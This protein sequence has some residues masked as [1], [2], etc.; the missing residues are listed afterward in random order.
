MFLQKKKEGIDFRF[1]KVTIK[2]A[3]MTNCLHL[4]RYI[5][6]YFMIQ[7]EL[8]LNGKSET[9]ADIKGLKIERA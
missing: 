4:R 2:D 8:E 7:S 6:P 5:R 9:R 3:D 1:E